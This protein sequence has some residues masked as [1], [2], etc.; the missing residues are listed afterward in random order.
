MTPWTDPEIS[1]ERCVRGEEV[2]VVDRANVQRAGG[3]EKCRI[4][5]RTITCQKTG[6]GGLEFKLGHHESWMCDDCDLVR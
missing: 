5:H 4:R 2:L 6:R 3:R 1:C